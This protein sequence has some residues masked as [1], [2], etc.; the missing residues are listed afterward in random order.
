MTL[1]PNERQNGQLVSLAV[2]QRIKKNYACAQ[3]WGHLEI[4]AVQ[5]SSL[6]RVACPNCLQA[7]GFVTQAFVEG[8]VRESAAEYWQAR[9]NLKDVLGLAEEPRSEDSILEELGF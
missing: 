3:C 4:Y 7:F 2:A 5:G 9:E 1:Q 8:R 6:V